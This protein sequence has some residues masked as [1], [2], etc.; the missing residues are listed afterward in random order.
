MKKVC[1]LFTNKQNFDCNRSHTGN[2]TSD[3]QECTWCTPT[4]RGGSQHVHVHVLS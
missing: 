2:S 1:L 4:Q 3:N